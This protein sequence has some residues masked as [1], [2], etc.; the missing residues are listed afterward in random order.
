MI[1]MFLS[2]IRTV[3]IMPLFEPAYQEVKR[4]K[5][6]LKEFRVIQRSEWL[7]EMEVPM[8]SDM[9][10]GTVIMKEYNGKYT[11]RIEL[12]HKKFPNTYFEADQFKQRGSESHVYLDRQTHER[13]LKRFL[14][15]DDRAMSTPT[16]SPD[17]SGLAPSLRVSGPFCVP[18]YHNEIPEEITKHH[19]HD[20][21]AKVNLG[22]VNFAR[23]A[24]RDRS[25]S[26][27]VVKTL[28]SKDVEQSKSTSKST[29]RHVSRRDQ[30]REA[31]VIDDAPL[32]SISDTPIEIV[33]GSG[34]DRAM[35]IF[36]K[37]QMLPWSAKHL[38]NRKSR[39][40]KMQMRA[41]RAGRSHQ[42]QV[43][44]EQLILVD[45]VQRINKCGPYAEKLSQSRQASAEAK[46]KG[47]PP[48]LRR[49]LPHHDKVFVNRGHHKRDL[50]KSNQDTSDQHKKQQLSHRY[51]SHH[52][53]QH[54]RPH[55]DITNLPSNDPRLDKSCHVSD[56]NFSVTIENEFFTNN[57]MNL[58]NKNLNNN[59][60][61][62]K[63]CKFLQNSSSE[64]IDLFDENFDISK[65]ILS[66]TD[67][68]SQN[69]S[70]FSKLKVSV[71]N[72][73]CKRTVKNVLSKRKT[74]VVKKSSK[75]PNSFART[76]PFNQR[77][78]TNYLSNTNAKTSKW[79]SIRKT[80]PV[81]KPEAVMLENTM[82]PD[83]DEDNSNQM[84]QDEF[85]DDSPEFLT[86]SP[87]DP[88][89][90]LGGKFSDQSTPDSPRTA[91]VINSKA[92]WYEPCTRREYEYKVRAWKAEGRIGRP[93]NS[94]L[95]F[96]LPPSRRN[97]H[98]E[99]IT[100]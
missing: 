75:N 78:I 38:G 91:A 36:S 99:S 58:N 42:V 50:H 8:R 60:N 90:Y 1:F 96:I 41:S 77:S 93:T 24:Y 51:D 97:A 25:S 80:K 43:C 39:L 2:F 92:L 13:W 10:P 87:N 85:I 81:F 17:F 14:S 12:L 61:R 79:S 37:Q 29:S 23:V 63:T 82:T 15:E 67:I 45:E 30:P 44:A 46:N 84:E 83:P 53:D 88:K 69:L 62:N 3:I 5:D 47:V 57:L 35:E 6:A 33:G 52:R 68:V 59:R 19:P 26:K 76:R 34:T 4:F 22:A 49:P 98:S 32:D 28:S 16:K 66:N 74:T 54:V 27:G 73:R 72:N 55:R 56:S 94:P 21:P 86:G 95:G 31:Y 9:I 40:I 7:Y 20:A 89:M 11:L 18:Q 64:S 70:N 65:T 100:D 48:S 71:A